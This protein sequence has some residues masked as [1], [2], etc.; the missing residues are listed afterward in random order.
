MLADAETS[1]RE[2]TK[3]GPRASAAGDAADAAEPERGPEPRMAEDQQRVREEL[4]SLI[5]MLDQGQDTWLRGA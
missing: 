5:A 4:E 3:A 1:L 2:A